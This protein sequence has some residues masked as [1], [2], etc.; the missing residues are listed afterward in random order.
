MERVSKRRHFKTALVGVIS[1]FA[2]IHAIPIHAGTKYSAIEPA[3][4]VETEYPVSEFGKDP[5]PIHL[6]QSPH[7]TRAQV[8]DFDNGNRDG[9]EADASRRPA[10]L[11]FSSDGG[12]R[13]TASV[14]LG[15]AETL[16]A[17]PGRKST[18]ALVEDS[19]SSSVP[20]HKGPA[21]R[22]SLAELRNSVQE[23]ALIAGD[24]GFFPKTL[25][26]SRDVPVR[27]YVTGAS[28]SNLCIMMDSF[29]V[30]KQI[31]SQKIEEISFTPN[32]PGTFRFYCPVNG[33][34]GQLV[35]KEL[36]T[37]TD[38]APAP[39]VHA[40]PKP[41]ETSA[42]KSERVYGY[43]LSADHRGPASIAESSESA[44][45]SESKE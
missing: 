41:A 21:H 38:E 3:D 39:V 2:A 5:A 45:T 29:S 32:L 30:K 40:N 26:V 8:V 14:S 43:G 33:M 11:E 16:G 37:A 25:F 24:L 4:D 1:G 17:Q 18:K 36:S 23:V 12:S 7:F 28:R 35:V 20:S 19:E 15:N 42:E 13:G 44:R 22:S 9:A 27:L 6:K 31:R 10:G 34:E